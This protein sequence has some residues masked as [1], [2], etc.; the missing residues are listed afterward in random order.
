MRNR[1]WLFAL[2]MA[3]CSSSAVDTAGEGEKPA[4]PETN[5]D[6][7]TR[8]HSLL[9]KEVSSAWHW[10]MDAVKRVPAHVDGESVAVLG[11]GVTAR[12]ATVAFVAKFRDLYK[13]S[14]PENS[15]VQVR[16]EQDELGMTH[17]RLQQMERGVRVSGREMMAH[18]DASG[19]LRSLDSTHAVGLEGVDIK[20][21]LTAE[22]ATA[23]AMKD[24]QGEFQDA[25]DAAVD[26][27]AELEVYA[28]D[29]GNAALAYHL[30]I[31]SDARN[32]W[33]DYLVDAHDGAVL[34]R[35]DKVQTVAGSGKDVAGTVRKLE[36]QAQGTSFVMADLSR[37]PNG[38]RTYTLKNASSGD[39]N[40]LAST[41][42]NNW[43][44]V[45]TGPGAAVNA[46]FFAGVVYDYYKTKH[47]RLSLD[48]K[49]ATI[50]SVA[51][52]SQ[53]LN[54][55]S[56]N[57]KNMSYGDGDGKTF[58]PL[59]VALDVVA[60]ELTHAVTTST[61]NLTYKDQSGALNE[62]VSDIF[63][64]IVEH[65]VQP[66]AKKN[67]LC[68][69]DASLNGTA[70][71]DL[72]HPAPKQPDHMSKYVNTTQDNGGVHTN[73]GIPNNAFY[74]MTM[75]GANDTSKVKVA[76]GLGWDKSAQ[77]W[78]RAETT[79]LTASTN[80]AGAAQATLSAAKDLKFT[81]NEV[82]IVECS[83]I[84]VGALPGT[85]KAITGGT[86]T[87]P[88]ADAGAPDSG[89]SVNSNPDPENPDGVNSAAGDEDEDPSPPRRKKAAAGGCSTSG[90]D[91]PLGYGAGLF[92]AAIGLALSRRRRRA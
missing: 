88:A 78:Y 17:V 90:G 60:H 29:E 62:S 42:V 23:T 41:N 13:L 8:A 48:G 69:E 77:L 19:V 31:R 61:S 50:I 1:V 76:A 71:R 27:K 9:S 30:D 15:L 45:T 56:W 33:M 47:N 73:S 91:A 32:L 82:N 66:D 70:F 44:V 20:A 14:D 54:N 84:A 39:A 72:A 6:P 21:T 59:A 7:Q 53:N 55:A 22:Q 34:R 2:M 57:G 3:G 80:M 10:S 67:W 26:T 37:T 36:V 46:H 65:A 16:E 87:A 43:D 74:L 75:G 85:C 83:W 52:V 81:D 18:Y 49:D 58:K 11:K 92:A 24:L 40:I 89:T 38:I 63:G 79:Y 12:H 68:G 5:V 25:T 51:H 28:P 86:G 35:F 64:E 4:Q